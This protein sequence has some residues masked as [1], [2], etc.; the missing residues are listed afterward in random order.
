MFFGYLYF[1]NDYKKLKPR[2]FIKQN[3][4]KVNFQNNIFIETMS[5][6][7]QQ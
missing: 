6:S 2:K 5:H 1:P 3:S 7:Y 4:S